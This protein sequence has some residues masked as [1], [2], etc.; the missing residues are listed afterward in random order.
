MPLRRPR[1]RQRLS[2]AAGLQ[3]LRRRRLPR[4]LRGSAAVREPRHHRRLHAEQQPARRTS[5]ATSTSPAA[6]WF[7]RAELS[8]NRSDFYDLF[9]PT[10]RSR[11]GY[12]AKLGYDWLLIYDEPRTLDVHLRPRL[13]R[14]DRHAAECAER[15]DQLHAARDRRGRDSTTPTCGARSAPSTTRRASPGT[16]VL[17]GKPRQRRRSRRRFA[18]RSISDSRCRSRTRRSGCARA[19]GVANGDRNNTRRQLLLRRFRQQLR[20]RQIGQALPRVRLAAR[21][22]DRR[23]QRAQLRARDGRVEP[24]AGR[25]RIG[26]ARRASTSTGCG[27]RS[28]P[29]GLWT[30]PANSALRKNYA[31]VGAQVDLRFSVLHW[32][33]MTLSVGLRGRLP[34]SQRAGAEWMISLK[35][36]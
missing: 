31:S 33:D 3:E 35:I 16:L 5:A 7:W 23:G 12:A 27:R 14:Q 36:M 10:K 26:R 21:I 6:T 32:Y 25:L 29:P 9:G 11:K 30:D 34:G 4:Q 2:G 20:R 22:R 19:A 17:Q 18:A 15:R 1:A 13:L 24:A 28:S 8:W